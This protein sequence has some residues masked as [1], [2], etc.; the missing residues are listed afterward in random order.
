MKFFALHNLLWLLLLVPVIVF[1]YLLKLKRREMVVSS[2]LLWSHLVKDVQANAPFQ[3]LK[4]NLLLLLQLLI[5]FLTV[6]ALARP[7]IFQQ[8]LGG[9]NV[10]VILDGSASM[11][12]RDARGARFDE[13]KALALRMVGD[14]RG[15]DKMMVL[16]STSRT[17][18]L[19]AF[20]TDKGELRRAISTAEARDTTTNLRDS[21][22]LAASVAGQHQGGRIYVV[23]DGAFPKM[24]ELDTHGAEIQFVKVGTR[25]DN[26]GLVAMDVRRTF[27]DEGGFQMFVAVRNFGE[28][29]RKCNL[30]FYRN[31]ALIDVRPVELP[32]ADKTD[33]FSE[34]AEVFTNLPANTGILRARLDVKDDLDADNEAYAQISA[35]QDI[36]VLLVTAGNLYLEKALNLDPHVKLSVTSPGAYNGQ[37]GF[38][39]VVFENAGPK[40]VGPGNHLY[41]NCGGPTAPVEIKG[42]ITNASILTWERVHPVMRYVKLSQLNMQEA[43]TATKRP[44]AVT[45]AEHEG[46]TA[47]AVGEKGGVKSAYVGFPL[48]KTEFPLRVAFPIFFNNLIQ[49]L[50]ASPGRTEGM[51]LRAGQTAPVE[52]PPTVDSVKV[53]DPDGKESTV[54][55]EGRLAYF[56]DTEK[57][58]IYTVEA[59]NFK[60]EFAVNLLSRDES[61]TRPQDKIE[62]GRR[63]VA[64]DSGTTRTASEI[65]RWLILLALVVLGVEWWVY[66]KRI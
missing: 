54:Q 64:A 59:A 5:A 63:P 25:S 44:W 49:W 1:F 10:V 3:K 34:K 42:K 13:A 62:F 16:L 61:A 39:V 55:P 14:M 58:G 15:G 41:I 21:V 53:T 11:Q 66:H 4:K 38:D 32:A 48:L 22:L 31:D 46:G 65:W 47:V 43:L 30:E 2:V 12:S 33:G 26:V 36:S 23:S 27:R 52:V 19:S 20:T 35:R 8:A 28:K 29:A 17:H 57:R 56:S 50:A 51:Q 40:Q 60:R 45:L 37:Q 24:D 9:A 7:A 6:L 18:R